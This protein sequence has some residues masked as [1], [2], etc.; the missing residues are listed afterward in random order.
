MTLFSRLDALP[1]EAR[2]SLFLLCVV[3]W[4]IAP[5]AS[6]LPWWTTALAALLLLW[7]GA[8]AWHA[9]PLPGR[10]VLAAL[11]AL[12]VGA[13]WLTHKSLLGRDPGVT[14]IVLLLALKTL[15]M[16]ARR[17][18][19]VVFFLGFFTLLS[20]FFY[21]QSLA[22][23]AA[24]L[25]ALLGLLTAVV[26]AH[27]PVGR[28][29][30]SDSLRIAGKLALWGAPVMLVLF[31]LFP[32]M[33]PLWGTPGDELTGRSGLSAEMTVGQMARLA[34]DD[35]VALRVRFDGQPPPRSLL[36]F[37]G[38][39]LSVFD[40]RQWRE[41]PRFGPQSWDSISEV[42]QLRVRG[43]PLDYEITLEPH[44]RNWLLTLDATATAPELSGQRARMTPQLQ[45]LSRRPVTD[46]LRY[47][48]QSHLDFQ[49][50]PL[51]PSAE[52]A[53]YTVLPD[54]SDPRTVALAAQMRTEMGRA[55]NFALVEA[56]LAR[57]RSGGYR[58]TLEPGVVTMNTADDFWFDSRQ[59][60]CEHI[61]SA[62]VVLMRALDIP[63]RIVTGY[64][65]GEPNPVDGYWTVRNSDAHAWAEVW[66]AGRGWVRVDPTTA[67]APGR[68]AELQ[69]LVAP[70]STFGQAMDSV[71]APGLVQQLRATWEAVNNGWN[72]WVLNYTQSRQFDLLR[73]LGLPSAQWQTLLQ[74][75]AGLAAACALAVCAWLWRERRLPQDGWQRLLE[76]ARHR[77][78]QAGLALPA[79]APPRTMASCASAQWGPDAAA[80]HDWLLR[81]EHQRYAPHPAPAHQAQRLS[82]LRRDFKALP[83]PIPR[84][85]ETP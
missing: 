47:R 48:A 13:T 8:L 57:L 85:P 39:V 78:Q 32:R 50:G 31:V 4:V 68:T 17:D 43:Q 82:Q 2:D 59:G 77:L 26:N 45:W 15:E 24:M 70:R 18:A 6:H 73:Q 75:L 61:A 30:L 76:Q 36:Y 53:A 67:V 29:P 33:A 63:A 71:I 5:H 74:W 23:A 21:S 79:H 12:A 65:G 54:G 11:L 42:P 56:A 49:Y 84:R 9:R 58:Y 41:T 20:H 34:L 69:R 55:D 60:F 35:S 16:R 38:P 19:L 51:Q 40:G 1:R 27:L 83:W 3:A 81:L 66:L 37:R 25:V 52:L 80:L 46:M 64:Q 10:W 44:R 28:P 22:I 14:L 72:Q 62:F 7:R